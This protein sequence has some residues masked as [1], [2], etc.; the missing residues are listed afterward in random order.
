ML[1][2]NASFFADGDP[3]EVEI[4]ALRSAAAHRQAAARVA[5]RVAVW[6]LAGRLLRAADRRPWAAGPLRAAAR[7]LVALSVAFL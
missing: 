1:I 4:A 2:P 7:G 3:A 6:R 5:R